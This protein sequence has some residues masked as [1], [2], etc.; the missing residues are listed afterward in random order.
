[1]FE[2]SEHNQP[3]DKSRSEQ[4]IIVGDALLE[5]LAAPGL[6][7]AQGWAAA[8]K[9]WQEPADGEDIRENARGRGGK[10]K[11]GVLMEVPDVSKEGRCACTE[12][13]RNP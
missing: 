5:A 1:M 9:R 10:R 12:L 13:V 7:V 8:P 2:R 4:G 6:R 11:Q 3:K